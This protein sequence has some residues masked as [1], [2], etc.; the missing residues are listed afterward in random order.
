MTKPFIPIREVIVYCPNSGIWNAMTPEL[1]RKYFVC[2]WPDERIRRHVAMLHAFGYNAVQVSVVGQM[3]RN[4]GQTMEEWVR[5]VGVEVDAARE[6]GMSVTQFV[7]GNAISSVEPGFADPH[8]ILDW[9]QPAHRDALR[10]EWERSA[11]AI[12]ARVDRVVTHW[13]DPGGAT[14]GCPDCTIHTAVEMHNAGM[15]I[16]RRVN[17]GI[18]GYFSNWMLYPGNKSYGHG[19]PGY[20]G[21][22][23]IVGD[24]AFDPGSG[25]A[26]GIMNCGGDGVHL[27]RC[28]RLSPADLR[29]VT[30]AG[31]K[32]AVWA[33]Y[34]TDM[35]IQPAL[36]VHTKLLQNYF[37]SL[38]SETADA[39]AW[40][41]VDDCSS[42]LNMHNLFVAGRLMQ[43]PSLDA[44]ALLREY[45]DGFFG[46]AAAPALVRALEA[47]EHA[48]CRSLRYS[49]KVGD[50]HEGLH[51][52]EL[53]ANELPAD[54]ADE[55]LAKARSSLKEL[56][57]LV[58]PARHYAAWPVTLEPQ[59]FLPELKTHVKAVEQMLTFLKAAGEA[60]RGKN[61]G[62]LARL[63]VVD[64]DPEHTAGLERQAY[65][66][67]RQALAAELSAP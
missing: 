61:P 21:V 37:R 14:A 40:H 4:A 48:R 11:R 20:D 7:W 22:T 50:P 45:A 49:L 52:A 30:A 31:R 55:G 32:A 66:Q 63:P 60:R 59:E 8:P 28:G 9:H 19:W 58:L 39:V 64:Y 15:E 42:G 54:W 25:V 10:R 24:P 46:A 23:S 51:E 33:W 44:Q 62:A 53:D 43:D 6:R 5:R 38:P 41:T 65:E 18:E 1:K 16:F 47:I 67:H 13:C 34:T 26:I 35:E 12:G 56:A 29:T 3:P 57:G 2:Y 36:H 17:P 27:D